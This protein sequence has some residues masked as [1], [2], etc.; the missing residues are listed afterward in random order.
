MYCFPNEGSLDISKEEVSLDVYI[1]YLTIVFWLHLTTLHK[2]SII[3]LQLL[4]LLFLCSLW[5][6]ELPLTL[7]GRLATNTFASQ[8]IVSF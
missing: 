1:A 3:A 8:M 2:N 6:K 7:F 4:G 5:F